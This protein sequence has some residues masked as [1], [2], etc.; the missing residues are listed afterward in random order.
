MRYWH[1]F[2]RI[3]VHVSV[4]TITVSKPRLFTG[5]MLVATSAKTGSMEH[6]WVS[7]RPWQI[8]WT[9]MSVPTVRS[10]AAVQT[11]L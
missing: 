1:A 11:T 2:L 7:R 5:F 4:L 6:V 3:H 8:K 9:R 10:R